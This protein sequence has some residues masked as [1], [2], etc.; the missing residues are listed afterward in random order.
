MDR[1]ESIKKEIRYLNIP[2]HKVYR[3]DAR[4]HLLGHIGCAQSHLAA[5]ELAIEKGW[6]NILILE[7]DMFFNK[8]DNNKNHIDYMLK[9]LGV[10]NWDVML[11]SANYNQVI[12][13]K[14]NNKFIK[15]LQAW[16]ACAYIVNSSYRAIL[17]DN[18]SQ[19]VAMLLQGGAK[20]S[21]ALDVTWMSLMKKDRWFGMYPVAGHQSSGQ[22]DI[23]KCSVDY[24]KLF[25]KDLESIAC[26][27]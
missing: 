14:S 15:P 19:S 10:I 18:F 6:G 21:F 22:S 8:N 24:E 9:A 11:L 20:H 12:K 27:V 25:Y 16:C 5:L 26:K 3:L 4:R 7:D 17:R 2:D 13:F 23:E 1:N